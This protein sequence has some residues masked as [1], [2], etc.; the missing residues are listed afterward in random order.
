[1]PARIALTLRTL[2]GLS[3]AEIGRA[4]LVSESTM[5]Q[6][7]VRAKRKIASAHIAYRIPPDDEL[8]ERLH[9]VLTVIYLIFN[10]GFQAAEGDRLIRGELCSEAIRLGRLLAKLMPDEAEV[11]GLLALMLLHDARRAARVDACGRYV[12]LEDQDRSQWDR[13]RIREGLRLL[14]RALRLGRPGPY[15]IQAAIAALHADAPSFAQTDWAQIEQL[16]E[17]LGRFG[18]SPV[19]EVNRAV[20]VA[21]AHGA[22]RGLDVL[23]PLLSEP[24]LSHYQPLYAAHAELL[25]DIGDDEGAADAYE[26]AI[27]LSRNAVERAELKRRLSALPRTHPRP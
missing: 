23:E 9:G 21:F 6:R 15:Q 25:R 24:R 8:P 1:M 13:G 10:E 27:E 14:E 7:L 17:A 22:D 20:A 3:T 18:R 11:S 16:Y 5:A 4:Y 26:R 19:V 12:S 2:G